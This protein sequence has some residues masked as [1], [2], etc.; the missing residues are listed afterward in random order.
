M[1]II[2]ESH[3]IDQIK[4]LPKYLIIEIIIV[5]LFINFIFGIFYY[6]IY[7]YNNKSFININ[8]N[9]KLTLY[10]FIYYSLS[11][12]FS[13]GFDITPQSNLAKFVSGLQ[14]MIAFIITTLFIAKIIK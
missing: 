13:L 11:T 3:I 6:L 2:A 7:L 9:R 5:I 12:F 8:N 10:D 14:L 4:S 1:S